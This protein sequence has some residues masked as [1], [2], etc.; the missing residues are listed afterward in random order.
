[1]MKVSKT[2]VFFDEEVLQET[3]G[4]LERGQVE[5]KIKC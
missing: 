5:L 4:G 3:M 1:M 2:I